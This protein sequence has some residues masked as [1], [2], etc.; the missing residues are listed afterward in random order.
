[1]SKP[2][3]PSLAKKQTELSRDVSSLE[4][5]RSA[6]T[7][8]APAGEENAQPSLRPSSLPPPP[9]GGCESAA[10]ALARGDAAAPAAILKH[11]LRWMDLVVADLKGRAAALRRSRRRLQRV[12][13]DTELAQ[14]ERADEDETLEE[15]KTQKERQ[16]RQNAASMKESEMK[17]AAATA[18]EK[19]HADRKAA[20]ATK[21]QENLCVLQPSSCALPK[22]HLALRRCTGFV[23]WFIQPTF[24]CR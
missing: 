17:Q 5:R 2:S 10:A 13:Q 23:A 20:A 15:E 3:K 22:R 1:M 19:F 6:A 12:K 14:V 4:R 18:L 9:L 8:A 24:C 16:E 21:L 7:P 11:A